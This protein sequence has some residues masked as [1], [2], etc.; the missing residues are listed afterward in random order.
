MVQDMEKQ[1]DSLYPVGSQC[2]KSPYGAHWWVI[3]PPDGAISHGVCRYCGDHRLFRNV[4]SVLLSSRR[5][6]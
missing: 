5:R 2:S 1:G 4:V 3:D 6:K